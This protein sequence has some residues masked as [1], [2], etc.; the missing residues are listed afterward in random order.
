ME[1][2]H[3]HDLFMCPFSR[4]ISFKGRY[5]KSPVSKNMLK[6]SEFVLLNCTLKKLFDDFERK[7]K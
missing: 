5:L 2:M 7:S 3:H 4:L 1:V 6:N